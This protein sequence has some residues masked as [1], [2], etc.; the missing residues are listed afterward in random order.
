MNPNPHTVCEPARVAIVALLTV[1][2]VT[3]VSGQ[4]VPPASESP[5]SK[6]STIILR[7]KDLTDAER[8]QIIAFLATLDPVVP[9][10]EQVAQ[11]E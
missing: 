3:L 1:M 7:P 11:L 5:Q 9:D 10:A 4:A 6:A 8:A 2:S